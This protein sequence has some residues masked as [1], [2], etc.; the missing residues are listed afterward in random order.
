MQ[1]Y[2]NRPRGLLCTYCYTAG[3]RAELCPNKN[4]NITYPTAALAFRS[5]QDRTHPM[6]GIPDA[7]NSRINTLHPIP[8]STSCP[9]RAQASQHK[10]EGGWFRRPRYIASQLPRY[11][12][13]AA[14]GESWTPLSNRYAALRSHSRSRSHSSNRSRSSNNAKEKPNDR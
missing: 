9:T 13:Q 1:M 11:Q 14:Y 2:L 5:A 4:Q 10:P 12:E 7:E 6:N 8:D 3:H